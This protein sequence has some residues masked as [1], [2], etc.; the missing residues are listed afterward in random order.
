MYLTEKEYQVALDGYAYIHKAVENFKED[1]ETKLLDS[2]D[3]IESIDFDPDNETIEITVEIRYCGCC[4]G[5]YETRYLP[6]SYL[7]DEDWVGR[8]KERQDMERKA[9]EERKKEREAQKEKER[10]EKRYQQFLEMKK[11]YEGE[12]NV[13]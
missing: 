11:E 13:E 9:E 4:P 5:D 6:I 7:W 12:D 10:E 2:R 3:W 8:E 1:Y